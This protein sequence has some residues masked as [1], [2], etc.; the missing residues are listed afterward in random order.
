MNTAAQNNYEIFAFSLK[1]HIQIY[2][3]DT[4]VEYL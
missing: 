2:H 1:N 4:V 3:R